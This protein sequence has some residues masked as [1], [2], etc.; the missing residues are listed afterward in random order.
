[1]LT[2]WPCSCG[3]CTRIWHR[4]MSMYVFRLTACSCWL[5]IQIDDLLFGFLFRLFSLT[6]YSGCSVWLCIQV[7][8]FD[9]VFRFTLYAGWLR[10][11]RCVEHS[12]RVHPEG[13]LHPNW[14]PHAQH[15]HV[16]REDHQV[17]AF[18][19][20]IPR[21]GPWGV[22]P[23]LSHCYICKKVALIA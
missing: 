20:E 18:Y 7:V 8:Q 14:E 12:E 17:Y 19:L 3:L 11:A 16:L 1:M 9:F 22:S 21:D 6:L 5:F 10:G 13:H 23:F 4:F 2:G 15:R